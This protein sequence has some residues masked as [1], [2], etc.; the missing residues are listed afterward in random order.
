[1]FLA[2]K[3]DESY[4]FSPIQNSF[5]LNQ[6]KF[7]MKFHDVSRSFEMYLWIPD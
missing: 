7:S 5:R 1:M 6:M 3:E 4:D 2:G